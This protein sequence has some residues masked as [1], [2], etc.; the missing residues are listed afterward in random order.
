MNKTDDINSFI[1]SINQLPTLSP[2]ALR[3][4]EIA[5]EADSSL[6][7]MTKLIESDQS[8]S[9][10]VL[11][12]ANHTISMSEHNC[13][14]RTVKHATALLGMN[15]IRSIALSF[16]VI[17]LFESTND[18]QFSITEYWRHN[19]ACAISGELIA[20]KLSYPQPEEAFMAGLLHDLGKLVL[21]EWKR[22]SY[23]KAVKSSFEKKTRVL[24]FEE[25]I[26]DVGHTQVAKLLMERW[27]FPESLVEAA[28]LHHQPFT[29]FGS[30]YLRHLPFIVKCA[31]SFCHLHRFGD[32]GNYK[33]DLDKDQLMICTGLS[34]DDL[35]HLAS[36][37]LNTFEDVA[38]CFD[39]EVST[40]DLYLSAIAR[41]NQELFQQQLESVEVK[42]RL[43]ISLHLIKLMYNL[44]ESLS[45]PISLL[46]AIKIVTE[47]VVTT[48]PYRRAIGLVFIVEKNIFKGC[49]KLN[50][51]K[52]GEQIILPINKDLSDA[53][54][55]VKLREQITLVKQIAEEL[56]DEI[57]KG[58][59]I[60]KALDSPDLKVQP[61]YIGGRTIGLFM[62]EFSNELSNLN[63]SQM[64]KN[65]FLRRYALTAATALD[66]LMKNES[67][68][69]LNEDK[70]RLA[71]TVADLQ[72]R[73]EKQDSNLST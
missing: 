35:D 13:E 32:S 10:K 69:K 31:N 3:I 55:N 4:V 17:N 16:I 27:K 62:I 42:Q 5:N 8:L 39:W 12:I 50:D 14:I 57:P 11:R 41:A 65:I 67:L 29:D 71:R 68:I 53:I 72:S 49:V 30:D 56:K 63:W 18:N 46:D 73:L 51:E 24:E 43:T 7:E 37:V 23:F 60:V 28:W 9:A 54:K 64:E 45:K 40:P 38:K 33:P 1:E 36:A 44:L 52:C 25:E 61:M 58:E 48:I 47:T 70:A 2:I 20:R 26:F 21:H 22:E 15:L 66:R 59:E 19:A 34:S 6:S